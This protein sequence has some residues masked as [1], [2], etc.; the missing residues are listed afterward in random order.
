[1]SV[2]ESYHEKFFIFDVFFIEMWYQKAEPLD[3][4]DSAT[5]SFGLRFPNPWSNKTGNNEFS[6]PQRGL[7][8]RR[9]WGH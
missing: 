5:A 8:S 4:K 3:S 9:G 1:M 2:I 6:M 7:R